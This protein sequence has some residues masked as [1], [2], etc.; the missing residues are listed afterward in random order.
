M[1]VLLVGAGPI[2]LAYAK[3]LQGMGVDFTAI[4]RGAESAQK[5]KHACG[6]PPATGGLADW[7][8]GNRIVPGTVA[9]VALSAVDLADAT[10]AL[11]DA[12]V[13]RILV[14]K[15]AGLSVAEID[16][17]AEVAARTGAEIYVAYNRRFYA[18]VQAARAMI[19]EDGGA[20]SFH[21]EFTEAVT[22]ILSAPK[23]PRLLA[24]WFL[25][26]STH[27]VDTAFFLGGAPVELS[28]EVSGALDWHPA[29][30]VFVGHGRTA[31]NARFTW[32]ADW[33]SA[34]RWGIDV[35]TPRR[36]LI[37][38]PMEQLA[39]QEKDSFAV[40][41]YALDDALDREYKPGFFRQTEA[42]LGASPAGLL[43]IAEHAATVRRWF[44]RICPPVALRQ[45]LPVT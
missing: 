20:T 31:G 12:D 3:V 16:R 40:T 4:G 36:R 21:F 32:H 34:G 28:G 45:A 35:R 29:G 43:P 25:A 1:N 7:L 13:R 22:R 39:V 38:Q 10:C 41:P 30:A 24:A 15:P 11:A 27:V 17:V 44:S 33:R 26:N 42:F 2:A 5:F 19:T 23:D 8:A 6:V 18:S 14:E 9:I 37:L